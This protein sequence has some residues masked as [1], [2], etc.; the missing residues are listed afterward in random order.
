[1]ATGYTA[2]VADGTITNFR[3][4]AMQ[5][6]RA[7]GALIEMRDDPMDTPIPTELKPSSY[8]ETALATANARL[9]E[10]KA[11]APDE[12]TQKAS[13]D[14]AQDQ[15]ASET[16]RRA[17]VEENARLRK[18]AAQVE[19]W[20]PPTP[21]HNG[22][23]DFMLEQLLISKNDETYWKSVDATEYEPKRWRR[24]PMPIRDYDPNKGQAFQGDVAIMP[25]PAGIE[26]ATIDEISPVNGRLILQEGEVTGHHHAITLDPGA[27]A[28]NFR[29]ADVA[30]TDML[31]SATPALR[32]RLSGKSASAA[33]AVVHM[34]RDRDAARAMVNAGELDRDDL[35]VGFLI[36]EGA[37]AVVKHEEHD[38]IRLPEGRYYVGRQVESAGEEERRVAD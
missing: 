8:H 13:A 24:I 19:A 21:D 26:I 5:C 3:T 12:I 29:P 10:L 6:A 32:R 4:F 28:R 25:V 11:M 18:M 34:Y 35:C 36:V 17:R 27:R 1:M 31:A 38:S 20:S 14:L 22:M 2:G 37:P 16:Y 9:A 30:V 33:K 7:F 15:A 23:K